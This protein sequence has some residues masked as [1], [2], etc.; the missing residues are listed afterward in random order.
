MSWRTVVIR[1]RAKLDFKMNYMIVRTDTELYK[2]YISELYMLIVESTAVSLTAVLINEL[3]KAKV[4]LVFCDETRNPASEVMPLY[5]SHNTSKRYRE[6]IEW[7]ESGKG[8]VWTDIVKRKIENQAQLLKVCKRVEE[9]EL[10]QKYIGQVEFRDPTHREAHAAKVYF[11]ALFGMEFSREQDNAINLALNYGYAILLSAINREIVGMG[12]MTQIG[13]CHRS[14]FN[15]FNF[16]C[17]LIEPLRSLVD[18]TV[19]RLD[20]DVFDKDIKLEL[21]QLLEE[22][23]DIGGTKQVLAGAI[24]LYCRSVIKAL[25]TGNINDIEYIKYEL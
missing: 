21:V 6:Q 12:Y 23:V 25:E 9:F 20:V 8:L 3:N 5:G 10:L 18:R 16:S 17:D 24:N 22:T 11:N 4:K 2:V 14:V 7:T 1:H 19:K 15:A 13:L